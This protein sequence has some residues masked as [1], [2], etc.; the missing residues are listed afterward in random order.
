MTACFAHACNTPER[1]ALFGA[2]KPATDLVAVLRKRGIEA[3]AVAVIKPPSP[4]M[5]VIRFGAVHSA[6]PS[7]D[8]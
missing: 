3:A 1:E 6:S 4:S 5:P 7:I 8:L 2:R